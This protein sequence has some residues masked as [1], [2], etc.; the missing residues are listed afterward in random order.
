VKATNYPTQVSQF[1][2]GYIQA[3][4]AVEEKTQVLF[5]NQIGVE[6]DLFQQYMRELNLS[7]K[8]ENEIVYLLTILEK[9]ENEIVFSV[10]DKYFLRLQ[11]QE[12]SD[13]L[14]REELAQEQE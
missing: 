5:D 2:L 13:M 12:E 14:T 6:S 10:E 11:A 4:S 7:E 9:E 1:L 8:E 3:A